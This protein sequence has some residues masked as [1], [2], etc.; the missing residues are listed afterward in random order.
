MR[1]LEEQIAPLATTDV[2]IVGETAFGPEVCLLPGSPAGGGLTAQA[3]SNYAAKAAA[4]SEQFIKDIT[5]RGHLDEAVRIREP[6]EAEAAAGPARLVIRSAP[7][8]PKPLPSP[9]DHPVVGAWLDQWDPGQR[10]EFNRRRTS[11]ARAGGAGRWPR[12]P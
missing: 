1:K 8:A 5:R 10:R 6:R 7:T 12:H 9:A 11:C 2:F 3:C 4:L